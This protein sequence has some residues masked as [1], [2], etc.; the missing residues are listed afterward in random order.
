[1]EVIDCDM[2]GD[3]SNILITFY[4]KWTVRVNMTTK[5][6]EIFGQEQILKN[7]ELS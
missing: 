7:K 3:E 1:M 6:H 2:K 4:R 5:T